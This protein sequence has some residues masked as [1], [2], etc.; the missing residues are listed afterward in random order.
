MDIRSIFDDRG[1]EGVATLEALQKCSP[2]TVV[3]EFDQCVESL[4]RCLY[5]VYL[6]SLV[7]SFCSFTERLITL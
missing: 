5:Y 2:A 1:M 4:L 6:A 3:I 7:N